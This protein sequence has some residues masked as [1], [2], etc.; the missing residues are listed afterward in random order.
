[1]DKMNP[2]KFALLLFLIIGI[3]LYIVVWVQEVWPEEVKMI[4]W[5]GIVVHHSGSNFDNLEKIDT[6][7]RSKGWDCC[8][9]HFVIE[10]GGEVKIGRILTKIGAH[11]KTCGPNRN[12]SHIGICLCGDKEF[13]IDQLGAL[14]NLCEELV[15]DFAIVSIERH[16]EKCPGP[17][18]D[19]ETLE[20]ELLQ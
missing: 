9:Y 6:Y 11:A 16:H 17:G 2:Y 8:G 7:H 15:A 20:K 4:D 13:N 1:M 18:I 5:K 10:K 19:V 3:I 14:D 12:K